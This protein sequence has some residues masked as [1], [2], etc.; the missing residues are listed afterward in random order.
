MTGVDDT[1]AR[2]KLRALVDKAGG[3]TALGKAAG[4][5][6][7]WIS[8]ITTGAKPFR[9]AG[10]AK[11]EDAL[12]LP[13]GYFTDDDAVTPAAGVRSLPVRSWDDL[14]SLANS[15]RVL[16][17][18]QLTPAAYALLMDSDAMMSHSLGERS[19][20]PGVYIIIE[21]DHPYARGDDV[22]AQ[23]EAGARPCVRRVLVDGPAAYL[24]PLNGAYGGPV[25]IKGEVKVLGRVMGLVVDL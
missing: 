22:L 23:L 15:D 12:Q 7:G 14:A 6:K 2:R 8:A 17:A 11:L 19:I 1:E 20:P 4:M 25:K 16:V 10:R 18:R 5:S 9:V 13:R 21:P 24:T 3:P